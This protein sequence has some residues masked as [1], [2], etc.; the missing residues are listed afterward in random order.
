MNISVPEEPTYYYEIS[1]RYKRL[2]YWLPA[3]ILKKMISVAAVD[4]K[5]LEDYPDGVD[6]KVTNEDFSY[7]R[8][9]YKMVLHIDPDA[10]WNA[11]ITLCV[12]DTEKYYGVGYIEKKD[13]DPLVTAVNKELENSGLAKQVPIA[14]E[15]DSIKRRRLHIQQMSMNKQKISLFKKI[16]V[17]KVIKGKPILKQFADKVRIS[18][19]NKPYKVYSA[20]Q[21]HKL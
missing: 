5:I 11:F 9:K 2:L 10:V 1:S 14:Q 17:P 12:Q 18:K 19:G 15:K 16:N 8:E 13:L 21:Q 4:K 3:K 7:F 6:I 20:I